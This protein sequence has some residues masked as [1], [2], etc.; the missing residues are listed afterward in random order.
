[1]PPELGPPWQAFLD[2]IDALLTE[3]V[4]LHCLGGFVLTALYG[5][6]RPTAD[7]DVLS[8]AP[9]EAL[10]R[11]VAVAGRTSPLHQKHGLYVDAVTVAEC[12]DGYE[13]RLTQIGPGAW[14][15]LRVFALEPHDLALAKLGRNLQRD[16]DDVL[17]LVRAARLDIEVLRQRYVSELRPYL[18][19]PEREDLTLDLWI[20]MIAEIRAR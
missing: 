4:E 15:N 12:P 14:R 3:P 13:A 6:A 17:F 7:V 11:L 18:G 9:S 19:N 5:M 10:S 8:V 16:R 2:D 1:M 20:E